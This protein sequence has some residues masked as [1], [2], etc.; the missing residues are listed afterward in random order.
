MED[1]GDRAE[2]EP[3]EG[4]ESDDGRDGGRGQEL[5]AEEKAKQE[6]N[7]DWDDEDALWRAFPNPPKPP[8]PVLPDARDLTLAQMSEGEFEV[9][10]GGQ[11]KAD[12]A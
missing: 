3:L 2:G 12:T 7:I 4:T 9:S 8:T 6:A 5:T 1:G 11:V 10:Y